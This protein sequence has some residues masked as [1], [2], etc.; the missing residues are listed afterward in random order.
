MLQF[1]K[2]HYL[3]VINELLGKCWKVFSYLYLVDNGKNGFA[4]KN[5]ENKRKKTCF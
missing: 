2:N 3:N 1:F 5:F 4:K